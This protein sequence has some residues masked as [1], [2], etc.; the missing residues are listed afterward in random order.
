MHFLEPLLWVAA[1]G[2]R[3][4]TPQAVADLPEGDPHVE[5]CTHRAAIRN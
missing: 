4:T 3:I 5:V 2:F 1:D